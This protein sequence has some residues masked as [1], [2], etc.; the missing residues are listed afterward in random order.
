[1]KTHSRARTG[2]C[3]SASI[4]L[5]QPEICGRGQGP[6][7][8]CPHCPNVSRSYPVIVHIRVRNDPGLPAPVVFESPKPPENT[9]EPLR[10]CPRCLNVLRSCRA[11]AHTGAQLLW[12]IGQLNGD[13]APTRSDQRHKLGRNDRGEIE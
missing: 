6:P 11:T 13:K 8:L 10:P 4:A 9:Q 2:R 5:E 12:E 7:H 3:S 1:M